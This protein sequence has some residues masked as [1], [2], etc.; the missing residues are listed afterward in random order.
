MDLKV[1][2][3][4]TVTSG[5]LVNYKAVG[6]GGYTVCGKSVAE[7]KVE[8]SSLSFT[9]LLL[10]QTLHTLFSSAEQSGAW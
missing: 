8:A 1:L 3:R 2:S 10:F 4:C 6:K 9:S 7:L 5:L